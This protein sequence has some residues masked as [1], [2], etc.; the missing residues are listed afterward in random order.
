M[1]HPRGLRTQVRSTAPIGGEKYIPTLESITSDVKST[2]IECCQ[3]KEPVAQ[4][5]ICS[6]RKSPVGRTSIGLRLS[7]P[8]F[9]VTR[10]RLST[11][12]FLRMKLSLDRRSVGGTCRSIILA[13]AKM[14]RYLSTKSIGRKGLSLN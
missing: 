10:T 9:A 2:H 1:F 14:I 13:P 11:M 8:C 4:L 5:S 6:V 3:A 7:L 12:A